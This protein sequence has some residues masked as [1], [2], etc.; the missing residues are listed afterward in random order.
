VQGFNSGDQFYSYLKDA[1]DVLYAEG[2]V[3]P[4]M[5]SI[6]LHCRLAGRPARIA[7]LARFLDHVQKHDKVWICRRVEIARHWTE[8]HPYV[9]P[10]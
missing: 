2:E 8:H 10:A 5:L 3:A 9:V 7:A 6:G 4:K 1:F